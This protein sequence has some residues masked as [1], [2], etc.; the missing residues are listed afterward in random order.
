MKIKTDIQMLYL[1][2]ECNSLSGGGVVVNLHLRV[3]GSIPVPL[4]RY[5]PKI[6]LLNA[7]LGD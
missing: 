6:E 1:V 2:T 5:S 3:V 4:P 7:V